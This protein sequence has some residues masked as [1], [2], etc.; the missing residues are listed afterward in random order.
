[1]QFTYE[2]VDAA[3]A[4][5]QRAV[6]EPFTQ[7]VRELLD[8]T[9]R[10]RAGAE[11]IAAAQ[12]AIEAI[13]ATLRADQMDGPFGVRFTSEGEGMSWGNPV[14]G[15]R[16]PMAPPLTV[17][18]GDDR[19]WAEFELGA[20]YEGPPDHVHGGISALILDHLLGEVASGRGDR[21]VF[22]GTI[23]LRYLRGTPLGRLRCEA[24]TER[25]DGVKTYARGF[26]SDAE[27]PTVEAEGVFIQPA[28]ARQ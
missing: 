4:A 19:C 3:E 17:E 18:H 7:A 25:I 21:P 10:T 28:W 20:A 1:M 24:W 2:P 26:I 23:S 12:A 5:A 11:D 6:Y 13:T 22:T 8:A 27:G 16:N 14:I 9:I 15:V